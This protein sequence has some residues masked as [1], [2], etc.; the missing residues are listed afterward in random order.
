[1][2]TTFCAPPLGQ[3]QVDF[4]PAKLLGFLH[5]DGF[6]PGSTQNIRFL[7]NRGVNG[8]DGIVSSALG[9]SAVTSEPLVLVLGDLSF[10][11]DMNGLLAASKYDI[12]ATIIIINND[13]GGIFSFLPQAN[14]QDHFE[15]LF[16]T[17]HGLTFKSAADMYGLKYY[18]PDNREE[19][20]DSVKESLIKKRVDLIEVTT[21][22]SGNFDLHQEIWRECITVGKDLG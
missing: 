10:Y 19:F 14:N 3:N 6:F 1:M 13:G 22:R 4:A 9:A 20:R 16:G 21:S 15:D 5:L 17:P 18:H 12:S 2:K 11:H 7:A 8:I